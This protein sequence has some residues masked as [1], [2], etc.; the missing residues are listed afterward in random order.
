MLRSDQR[1][2]FYSLVGAALLLFHPLARGADKL[3]PATV[4]YNERLTK[5]VKKAM[6]SAISKHPE[7]FYGLSLKIR[8][9]VDRD[10]G[11][12]NVKVNLATFQSLG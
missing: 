9:A 3:P 11:V 8:Y 6:N 10:G 2:R 4:A 12:H 1:G 5:V 7:R